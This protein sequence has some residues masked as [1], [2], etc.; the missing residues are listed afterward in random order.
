M[1][2]ERFSLK[3]M[4]KIPTLKKV[5]KEIIEEQ[6]VISECY[7]VNGHNLIT[8]E[9]YLNGQPGIK[10]N[11]KSQS[12]DGT[13]IL[14]AVIGD[15]NKYFL[16]GSWTKGEKVNMSCPECKAT[17]PVLTSCSCSPEAEFVALGLTP[18]IDFNNSI[19]LCNIIGCKDSYSMVKSE[20][21]INKTLAR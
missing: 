12:S 13:V 15:Y 19:A 5:T 6:V 2:K 18:K 4:L 10:L 9:H 14:S 1:D 3:G 7:C 21:V 11:F 16:E 8:K 20:K 17:L